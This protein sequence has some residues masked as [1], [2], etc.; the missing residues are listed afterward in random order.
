[1]FLTYFYLELKKSLKVM[2]HSVLSMIILVMLV[3]GGIF[4][5]GYTMFQ[6]QIFQTITVG[7]VIPDEA[8]ELEMISHFISSMDSVKSICDFSYMDQNTAQKELES[9]EIQAVITLPESL[10]QDI[11][12]G[13]SAEVTV[14][15]PENTS[16]ATETFRQVLYDGVKMIQ[17]A[18]AG[19]FA[20]REVSELYEADMNI[21][22]VAQLIS[23]SYIQHAFERGD[24]FSETVLLPFGEMDLKQYY[25]ASGLSILLLMSGILFSYL[26]SRQDR[27]VE[28][29]LRI[30]GVG[31]MSLSVGKVLIM[32]GFI[33]IFC[34]LLYLFLIVFGNLT[35]II[36]IFFELSVLGWMCLLALSVAVYFHF[37]YSVFHTAAQGTVFLFGSNIFLILC[38]GV[39]I[40][41]VYLP[42]WM[43]KISNYSPV[44]Y[45]NRF[46][47]DLLFHS[48]NESMIWMMILWCVILFLLGVIA[49]W[50][51]ISYGMHFRSRRG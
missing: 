34:C 29:M 19:V 42:D 32:T 16:L 25:V 47:A 10:Y 40:P 49:T 24:I 38:S 17:T 18:E 5:L 23:F 4:L 33:W 7:I 13:Q 12:T 43:E 1:M 28:Q 8:A 51:N 37:L 50:Y 20:S 48:V 11:Y 27:I 44:N 21:Y 35:G 9:G 22:E 6:S 15:F 36:S 41:A 26:Y 2:M 45:M 14:Y 3:I 30:K 46:C 31:S 39:I